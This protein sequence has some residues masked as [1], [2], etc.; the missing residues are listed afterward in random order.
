MVNILFLETSSEMAGVEYSTFFLAREWHRQGIHVHIQL[1]GKGD[2]VGLCQKHGIPY[3]IIKLPGFRKT[4]IQIGTDYRLP[5]PLGWLINFFLLIR[6][7]LVEISEL[8]GRTPD[9]VIT[10][11]MPAHFYG[12]LACRLKGI[13]CIWHVQDFVSERFGGLYKRLFSWTGSV[14]PSALV[15]DGT[16]ILTQYTRKTLRKTRVVLNGIDTGIYKPVKNI[17]M[18]R[19]QL[20]LPADALII[21]NVARMTPWKGQ[22]LLIEAFASLAVRRRNTILL[23]VGSA[24]LGYESYMDDLK[25]RAGALG[26]EDRIVFYGYAGEVEKLMQAMDIFVHCSTEKDT[27]PLALLSALSAGLPVVGF[28]IPGY[29][30]VLKDGYNSV[31]C[32][33]TG[34]AALAEGIDFLVRRKAARRR[35]AGNAR[36][37]AVENFSIRTHAAGMMHVVA[38]VL[39]IHEEKT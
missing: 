9:V 14:I 37:S 10:K 22:H 7:V 1:P 20:G 32:T 27:S 19:K 4:S 2:F 17:R 3:S 33:G 25:R 6:I 13:P 35:L 8:K 26:L 38:E 18:H 11:G 21:G 36:K 16:P 30:D 28:D 12:G 15:A 24:L 39:G 23:L 31:V 29:S 34:D 5:N